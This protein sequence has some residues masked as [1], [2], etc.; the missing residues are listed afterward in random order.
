MESITLIDHD[1]GEQTAQACAIAWLRQLCTDSAAIDISSSHSSD[2]HAPDSH[3]R[4][5]NNQAA[6]STIAGNAPLE[7]IRA[8]ACKPV[9]E[10]TVS[11]NSYR[12]NP[13]SGGPRQIHE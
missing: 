5:T 6:R 3:R 2:I 12:T 8:A 1:F 11:K 9:P 7:S 13:P 4:C 10:E